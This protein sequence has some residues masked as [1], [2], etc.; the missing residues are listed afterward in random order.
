MQCSYCKREFSPGTGFTFIYKA[1]KVARFCSRKC[2]KHLLILKRK[3]QDMKWVRTAKKE[4]S[5]KA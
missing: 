1:G 3:P 4:K 2:E 5:V